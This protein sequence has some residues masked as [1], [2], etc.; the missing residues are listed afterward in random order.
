MFLAIFAHSRKLFRVFPFKN[1]SL[2]YMIPLA[3]KISH[4]LSANHN[5]ELRCVICTF[6]TGVTLELHCSQPIRMELFFFMCIIKRR[7]I[8]HSRL[9]FIAYSNTSNFAVKNTS[10]PVVFSTVFSVFGYETLSLL[11]DALRQD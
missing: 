3:Y 8:E 4:C 9:C 6:C 1:L 2:L 7:Y 10:L 11:F 5:P